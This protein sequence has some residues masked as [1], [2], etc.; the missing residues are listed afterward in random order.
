[1]SPMAGMYSSLA[2]PVAV[3]LVLCFCT[4][5]QASDKPEV[6]DVI[7]VGGGLSGLWAASELQRYTNLSVV[8]LE[9]RARVG[10]RT[11]STAPGH[12]ESFDLGAHWVGSTQHHIQAVIQR[13]G[14]E[15]YH[16]FHEGTKVME[17]G[18]GKIRHYKT[19][20]PWLPL[21]EEI[22]FG[23]FYLNADRLIK[24]TPR[25]APYN[26]SHARH[27]DG[28]T[29]ET[30][31]NAWPWSSST[32]ELIASS[33]L[34]VFGKELA[35]ISALQ[36]LQYAACAGGLTPLLDATKGG[37]QE[38]KIVGG[39]Q[40]LS[41]DLASKLDVRLNTTVVGISE[42]TSPQGKTT[43]QT[44]NGQAFAANQVIMAIPPHL[45]GSIWYNPPLPAKKAHLLAHMTQG[46]L[47]KAIISYERAFWRDQGFS[48][49]VVSSVFP[50]SICYDDVTP[51]GGVAALVCFIG[52][53]SAKRLSPAP[54]EERQAAVV[55]AL[56]RY[57]GPDAGKV[58]G[59][60][61]R[62]W[63]LEPF[64][65]GCP[66]GSLNAGAITQWGDSLREPHGT[67]HFG[68]TE[69]ATWFYGFMNGAVQ[70]G[71]RC[72]IE[73]MEALDLTVPEAMRNFYNMGG[74]QAS[75]EDSSADIMWA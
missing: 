23:L 62:D 3:A 45:A 67:V 72:A 31:C 20:L 28:M 26:A 75:N 32:K 22:N 25:A 15:T 19:V 52:G 46:H 37:A 29:V 9:G 4:T 40:S 1:L 71:E 47:I 63:G 51:D 58:L 56:T 43:V 8:V 73:V 68:G 18:E 42:A 66:T 70:A 61:E 6:A 14:K 54:Q 36:L 21:L 57:F 7:V 74:D 38:F 48:G 53:E 49:E 59:Y 12:A 35:D 41:V 65:G 44:L 16:Q 30:F 27:F 64:T 60:D 24:Q 34:T 17:L 69:T 10:G 50:L 55:K 5:T 39:T 2:G 13:L 11:E 33:M